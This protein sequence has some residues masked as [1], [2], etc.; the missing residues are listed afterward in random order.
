LYGFPESHAASFALIAY[1]SAYLKCHYLAAFTAALLNNQPMGFYAPATLVK[2]AQRHGLH[3]RP[4]DVTR[5]D[6]L[7]TIEDADGAKCVRL[8]LNYVKGVR[9][10]TAQAILRARSAN[11]VTGTDIPHHN[12]TGDYSKVIAES[13]C[14][15]PNWPRPFTSIQDLVDRVPAIRKDEL[16]ALAEV[17][18]LNFINGV[19]RRDALWQAELAMRP[20]G[21]LFDTERTDLPEPGPLA[22]MTDSE[23]LN[24]DFR[25]SHLT[26]GRH[27]MSFH[28][29]AM[30]ELGV[31]TASDIQSVPHGRRVRTAGCVICRQRPGTAKGLVFL[32]LEDETG[33]SNA[34]VMPDMY[35]EYRS[36]LLEN[37]YL[38]LDGELQNIDNVVTVK[39]VHMTPLHVAEEA[40]PSHDFR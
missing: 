8:G 34:V 14:P 30:N 9:E 1:A 6:W 31:T 18:A 3:F 7:C 38:L 15:S 20:A 37:A 13:R 25:R 17:G 28:R 11:W 23:R 12:T 22:Q 29:E 33:V 26:I 27:P 10:E 35:E 21:P 16:R 40:V 5:S 2:D 32:S 39:V 4:I 36:T 24:T 19:H